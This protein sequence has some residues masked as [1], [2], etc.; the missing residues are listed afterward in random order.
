MRM[1]LG[2]NEPKPQ[3]DERDDIKDRR[4]AEYMQKMK[5]QGEGR[6]TRESNLLLGE[7]VLVKQPRKNKWSTPYEPVFY[8]VCSIRGSQVT[9]R[10]VTDGRTVCRDASQFKI[11]NAVI[12][13]T[14]EPEKNEKVETPQAVPDMRSQKRRLHPVHNLTRQIPRQMQQRQWSHPL[15]T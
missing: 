10:R 9:A 8:V 13:T 7:F 15:Q 4:D 5:Q 6:K 1:K 12:N 14:D 3:R 2:F 11:A